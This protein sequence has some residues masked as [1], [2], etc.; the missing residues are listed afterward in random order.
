MQPTRVVLASGNRGKLAELHQRLGDYL[1]I[2]SQ[3]DLGIQGPPETGL[4][5]LENAILKARHAA[6]ESGM[7]ALADDSGLCV[8][9]LN[10]APGIY[11]S[12]FAGADASDEANN[13]KLLELL[14]DQPTEQ[15]GARFVCTLVYIRHA[16]DPQPLIGSG[17]WRGAILTEPRGANGFGYDPL[18]YLSERNCTSAELDPELKNAISHRG[19]AIDE[20]LARL[21]KSLA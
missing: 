3:G 4:T 7:A 11:S 20:L 15:R 1:D 12:R 21:E 6:Q 19:Q 17:E 10:G 16:E 2:R 18:F 9:A 5:F 8:D 13:A 14:A